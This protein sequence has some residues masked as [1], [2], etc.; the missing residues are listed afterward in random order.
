MSA[1]HPI[2]AVTGS[3]GAGTTTTTTAFNHIFRQLGINAAVI[4]GDSFHNFTRT[5]ME[6]LI[7]KSKAENQN[8]SYFGFKSFVIARTQICNS[9]VAILII[10]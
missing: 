10:K 4:E 3:S 8:L 6:V 1:K 5:E 2:I 9:I 7:R